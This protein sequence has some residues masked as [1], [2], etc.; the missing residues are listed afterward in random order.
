VLFH[1][2]H[3]V[4]Q[5][6]VEIHGVVLAQL[7]LVAGVKLGHLL[8]ED[9]RH[10]LF[11]LF[12]V[13]QFVLGG[14]D[15]GMHGV[16]VDLFLIPL[17]VP[18]ALFDDRLLVRVVVDGES[19]L[20]AQLVGVQ[21]EDSQAEPVE[22][23]DEDFPGLLEPRQVGHPVLHFLGGLVGEG[24]GQDAEGGNLHFFDQ[25]DDSVGNDS[26]LAGSRPGQDK[27]RPG[28]MDDRLALFFVQVLVGPL[29]RSH[30]GILGWF[31]EIKNPA[32]PFGAGFGI[33]L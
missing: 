13:F 10:Q 20:V 24:D 32:L 9:T 27:G 26:G 6:I 5:Q 3:G 21:L 33:V 30:N 8:L 14:A 29:H 15:V 31:G 17:Q 19:R 1:Q 22:G 7:L 12:R 11:V 16:G 28:V 23:A 2:E 18:E 25:A 4:E